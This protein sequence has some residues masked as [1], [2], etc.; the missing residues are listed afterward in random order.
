MSEKKIK[1]VCVKTV[2][3]EVV[4][5]VKSYLSNDKYN[6]LTHEEIAL[7]CGTSATSVSRIKNGEYD[8]LLEP[9]ENA[10]TDDVLVPIDYKTLKHLIACEDAVEKLIN[11]AKLSNNYEGT[12]F[13]DYK[14]VFGILKA[15]VPEDV[16]RKLEELNR[17]EE[18]DE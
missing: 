12:L 5:K 15:Y 8:H 17:E 14:V 1:G 2:T 3:K 6:N 4:E 11:C 10:N 9:V 13:I 7:L 18:S 16:I